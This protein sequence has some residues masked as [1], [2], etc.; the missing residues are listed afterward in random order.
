MAPSSSDPLRPAWPDAVAE[1]ARRVRA[2]REQVER[3]GEVATDTDFY[4]PVAA[5]FRSDPYRTDDPALNILRNLVVPGETW[6]DIGAGGGRLALP[7]ALLAKEVIAVEPSEGMLA[8]LRE[9]MAEHGISN[10]RIVHDRWPVD[11]PPSADVALISGVGNDVE[12]IGPFIEAMEASARRICVIVSWFR[13]PRAVADSLWQEIYGE[14]RETLPALPEFLALLL[15][16]RAVF[17]VRLAERPAI[18]YPGIEEAHAFLRRQLWLKDG[19]DRDQRLARI[20][21]ER[22]SERDG[23]FAV[24]WEPITLGIVTWST[25]ALQ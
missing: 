6:L 10:V 7:I 13:S 24:S 15:A 16:R 9:G 11:P 19:S 20:L 12:D 5:F 4:A 3:T 14:P 8:V 23:R 2:D 17:E 25:A 1:W 21:A 18:S 22:L